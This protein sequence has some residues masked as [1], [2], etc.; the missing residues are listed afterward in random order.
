MIFH[1][2][3]KALGNDY[4]RFLADF[5]ENCGIIV[6][7]GGMFGKLYAAFAKLLFKRGS[8]FRIVAVAY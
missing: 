5:I 6:A 4:Q 1:G 8:E 7:V 2:F 3:R